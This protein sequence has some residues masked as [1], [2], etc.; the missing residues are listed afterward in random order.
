MSKSVSIALGV[1]WGVLAIIVGSGFLYNYI[2]V[3]RAETLDGGNLSKALLA[4]AYENQALDDIEQSL[5]YEQSLE[6]FNLHGPVVSS[7]TPEEAPIENAEAKVREPGPI[8]TALSF[9]RGNCPRP[10]DLVSP[11]YTITVNKET[12]IDSHIPSFLVDVTDKLPTKNGRQICLDETTALYLAD[13]LD[14]AK[15]DGYDMTITSGYRSFATQSVLLD[16]SIETHGYDAAI[17]RVAP[18]GHSEHQLGT[19]VD[20]A[21]ATNGYI[22]AGAAF[23]NSPEY[24]WMLDNAGSFGFVLSYPDGHQGE[25]GYIFEPWHWRFVGIDN[26]EKFNLH[27]QDAKI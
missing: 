11:P 8:Q 4:S 7:T 26:V 9:G 17:T 18:P 21:A 20:L 5:E 22:S 6:E 12:G 3:A 10:D 23:G 14:A 2:V 27:D 13:L 24:Q 15:V 1:V 25:T 19:T 16:R